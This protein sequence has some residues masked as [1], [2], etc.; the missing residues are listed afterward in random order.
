MTEPKSSQDYATEHI[1][2]SPP[3]TKTGKFD[4]SS[5][6]HFLGIFEALDDERTREVNALKP[7]R[8]GGS[9]IGQ[10]HLTAGL[11]RRPAPCMNVFQTDQE[12]KIFWFDRI[13]K[14]LLE[15]AFTRDLLPARYE[16]SEVFLR[17]GHTIYTGGPGIS[18]L[19]SKG[20]CNLWL[21]ECWIYPLG[22]MAD[23]EARV[24]DYLRE[25]RSKILRISQAGTCDNRELKDCDWFRA[26]N[27]GE[28][29][30]WEVQCQHC[31]KYFEPV[32]TGTREDGSFWGVTWDRHQLP[33]GDWDIAK[34]IP[35]IRFE[36]PHCSKPSLDTPRTKSE[37]NRTGRYRLIGERNFRRRGFHWESVIDYPWEELVHLWLD[38]ENAFNRGD[39]RPKL[40]FYQKRRAIFKDEETLLKG[41]L[42]LRRS[43]YEINS[44]W[45]EE[46]ERFLTAD[47][48][49]EDMFWWSVRAW[50]PEKSRRLGFGK[51][52][53]FAALEEIRIKFNVDKNATFVD[54]AYLPK[55]DHGVYAACVQYGWVAVKGDDAHGFT[56]KLTHKRSVRRSYSER[57]WADPHG[58]TAYE[59]RRFAPLIRFSK[60]QMNQKVQELIDHGHWEEPMDTTDK[61][62]DKEYN[63]Q[64]GSR[65]KVSVYSKET[66]KTKSFFKEGKN[67]HARDLANMQCLGAM[68]RNCLPDPVAERLTASE[69]AENEQKPEIAKET[70]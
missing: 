14:T 60:P 48:Q 67:D 59:G 34:C 50:S 37:W 26:W 49:E 2:L 62:M 47:R 69:E 54:S 51:C 41:G 8:G 12:A 44:A 20:V 53:G 39:I 45:P 9:L 70:A 66:G 22:R 1:T 38:A 61:E 23:A 40:Q 21:D 35:T 19:Q 58:G 68:L 10:V 65:V 3:I 15:C 5:S 36:C 6:R 27:L 52:Y 13:E 28:V 25:E 56:H 4:C 31:Q 33:N 16:W 30:E 57:V 17:S 24:G 7:V 64:M 18:N 55:G 29:N 11:A 42:N 46:K 32:F 43:S 63:A